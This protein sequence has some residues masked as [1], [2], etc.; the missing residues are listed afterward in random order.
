[1]KQVGISFDHWFEVDK[2]PV[3]HDDTSIYYV[4]EDE[5]GHLF[6]YVYK[7]TGKTAVSFCYRPI[8][9]WM[10]AERTPELP[11]GKYIK[12][13]KENHFRKI[14]TFEI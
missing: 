11:K 13:D 2:R 5:D 8:R 10:F 6:P 4:I 7:D 9:F 3:P 1:M 12:R 14:G